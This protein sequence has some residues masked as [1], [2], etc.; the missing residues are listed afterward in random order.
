MST[1]DCE[2]FDAW[3]I[4]AKALIAAVEAEMMLANCPGG[5]PGGSGDCPGCMFR[6]FPMPGG[7]GFF[8]PALL[9]ER[10]LQLRRCRELLH[11]KRDGLLG[12]GRRGD[13]VEGRQ[14]P[15]LAE[16]DLCVVYDPHAALQPDV[17]FGLGDRDLRSGLSL[18]ER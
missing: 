6:K 2:N 8:S 7:R 17:D 12:L 13:R 16:V 14:L 11:R 4:C 1:A 18:L 5:M 10:M 9:G 15:G 3:L